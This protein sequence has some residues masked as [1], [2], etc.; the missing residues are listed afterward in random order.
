MI[1][2]GD[3]TWGQTVRGM[4]PTRLTTGARGNF[5]NALE[6]SDMRVYKNGSATQ[7]ASES[8]Y[9]LTSN[10]FDS[11]DGIV[12][13]AVDLS[14]NTDAGFYTPGEY[15]VVLYPDET[16]DSLSVAT[17]MATFSIMRPNALMPVIGL[18][19]GGTSTTVQL[20]TTA[21]STDG[22]YAGA[23]VYVRHATGE[24]EIFPQAA[25]AYVGST[26]TLTI[27]GTFATTPDTTSYAAPL[28][29]PVAGTSVLPD[30]NV[31]QVN[32]VVID[33]AGTA[34]DP[35]GPV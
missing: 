21:S 8:G 34:G 1:H 35:W 19:Q 29:G 22:A 11:L 5:S 32:A 27:D 3:F 18:A 23:A 16:L 31:A 26:R 24:V 33:G 15:C 9:T 25:T 30:V 2:L 4:F 12:S 20:P 17:V 14:D 28:L 13:W 6:T 7:R 10:T